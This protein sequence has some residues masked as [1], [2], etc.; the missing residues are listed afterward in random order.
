MYLFTVCM[1]CICVSAGTLLLPGAVFI[2]LT[3]YCCSG[4]VGGCSIHYCLIEDILVLVQYCYQTSF[5]LRNLTLLL[6]DWFRGF[7]VARTN[8][9]HGATH[10]CVVLTSSG[11]AKLS[12]PH[13]NLV[14]TQGAHPRGCSRVL[15]P[16]EVPST[17]EQCQMR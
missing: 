17:A 9:P 14:R 5:R 10:H 4:Q 7:T 8:F 12:G 15:F 13:V 11:S 6:R 2:V 1:Y 3:H 16:V